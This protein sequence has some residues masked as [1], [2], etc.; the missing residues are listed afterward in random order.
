MPAAAGAEPTLPASFD[1]G[2]CLCRHGPWTA[3][4]CPCHGKEFTVFPF[5]GIGAGRAVSCGSSHPSFTVASEIQRG[6]VTSPKS[7]HPAGHVIDSAHAPAP[8]ASPGPPLVPSLHHAGPLGALAASVPSLPRPRLQSPGTGRE[9]VFGGGLSVNPGEGIPPPVN[10]FH[11]PP[12]L[13]ENQEIRP[14][15]PS[16]FQIYSKKDFRGSSP[17]GSAP[18]RGVTGARLEG[19]GAAGAGRPLPLPQE[20][21]SHLP[22]LQAA[23]TKRGRTAR[24]GSAA[25]RHDLP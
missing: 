13:E 23:G 21:A 7:S 6:P 4:C 24:E 22:D 14:A 11:P 2:I 9:H 8:P 12:L 3:A 18:G 5:P 17:A 20:A 15:W 25:P 16:G 1:S 10:T 19:V